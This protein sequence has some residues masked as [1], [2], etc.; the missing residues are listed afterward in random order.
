MAD[1]SGPLYT[2]T[3]RTFVDIL[4]AELTRSPT[5]PRKMPTHPPDAAKAV[6]DILD[7]LDVVDGEPVNGR[8]IRTPLTVRRRD[9]GFEIIRGERRWVAACFVGLT[10]VTCEIVV[11]SDE[12]VIEEQL[13]ENGARVDLTPLEEAHALAVLRDQYRRDVDEIAAKTGKP[14]RLVRQRLALLQLVEEAQAELRA[15][16]ITLGLALDVAALQPDAQREAAASLADE[17][18]RT[19]ATEPIGRRDGLFAVRRYR[20]RLA[21]AGFSLAD[22]SLVAGAGSCLKCPKRSGNQA[23][24]WAESLEDAD[25]CTDAKCFTAKRAARIEQLETRAKVEGI[26]VATPADVKRLFYA[27]STLSDKS[28]HIDLDAPCRVAVP[29]KGA[30]VTAAPGAPAW[31]PPTWRE[32]FADKL[33]KVSL[34]AVDGDGKGHELLHVTEAT[35][36]LK[37]SGLTVEAKA[38]EAR[39]NEYR[40]QVAAPL[41][42]AQKPK[43]SALD[44]Q[45][46][47]RQA[48]SEARTEALSKIGAAAGRR[49][50]DVRFWRMLAGVVV[51]TAEAMGHGALTDLAERREIPIGKGKTLDVV[52]EHVQACDEGDCR[53]VVVELLA[54]VDEAG[55]EHDAFAVACRFYGVDVPALKAARLSQLKTDALG[56]ERAKRKAKDVSKPLDPAKSGK[57]KDP[58]Q[59]ATVAHRDPKPAN[60]PQPGTCRVCG[61]V[62]IESAAWADE[63][64]TLCAFCETTR[65]QVL[66]LLLCGPS[67][68]DD[69]LD[70]LGEVTMLD[71]DED[72]ETRLDAVL[73][74]LV[75]SGRAATAE[76]RY[77][78]CAEPVDAVATRANP[79]PA[80]GPLTVPCPSCTAAAGS[81]CI[82]AN[83]RPREA[84]HGPR[85][86]LAASQLPLAATTATATDPLEAK[87][88]LLCAGR[89]RPITQVH[90]GC[91]GTQW[92]EVDG[93]VAELT[94]AGRLRLDGK[95]LVA[96]GSPS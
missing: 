45:A 83:N 3:D 2:A 69:I 90:A 26:R 66:E 94:A 71:Q 32:V 14:A 33:P 86:K 91:K 79:E 57:A 7:T 34:I 56:V 59:R 31:S 63:T 87:I 8:G 60:M 67:T 4:V 19:G 17:H 58:V 48:D 27:G 89:G 92:Q 41:P 30:Q 28:E 11:M 25:T 12:Q 80:T 5:N 84:A 21:D 23:L 61:S 37:A 74:E 62:D 50:A 81:R 39:G 46:L 73:A 88:L 35:K 70:G 77:V 38:F 1:G 78:R 93:A 75:A 72:D 44:A 43:G 96:V 49:K 82:D 18:A 55:A 13:V 95:R 16:H 85:A 24:L 20:L 53:S 76:G 29:P 54:A 42:K 22:A 9:Q 52:L 51:R 68:Q 15:N 40:E 10:R 36:A 6:A 64:R 47:E 65:T